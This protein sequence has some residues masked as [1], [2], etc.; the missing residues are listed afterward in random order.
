M[1]GVL[2]RSLELRGEADFFGRP[3]PFRGIVSNLATTPSAHGEPIRLWISSTDATALKVRATIDRTRGRVR[4]EL[5]VEAQEIPVKSQSLGHPEQ[6]HLAV[7][8]STGTLTASVNV[9]RDKL[10]GEIQLVQKR[11]GFTT[12]LKCQGKN[13]P[14]GESLEQSLGELDS[15]TTRISLTGTIDRPSCELTSNLGPAVAA[16]LARGL[17]QHADA[18]TRQVLADAQRQVDERLADVERQLAERRKRFAI[19][20]AGMPD[21]ID[22]IARSQTRRERMSSEQLGRRLPTT[23][24]LR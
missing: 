15:L 8:P 6:L 12:V 11:P 5:V 16:A 4:E 2:L 9:D 18:R 3:I 7:A 22:A 1:P 10:S 14:I 21:R 13:S 23:S 24:I 19:R 20:T 17:Q